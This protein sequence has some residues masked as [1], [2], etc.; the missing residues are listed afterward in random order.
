MIVQLRG[1]MAN[2]CFQAAFGISVAHA[3]QEPLYFHKFG[4]DNGQARAYSLGAFNI[5]VVF[6]DP[7]PENFTYREK[8]FAFDKDALLAPRGSYYCGLWQTERYFV[9]K[10][11]RQAFTPKNPLSQRSIEWK[12]KLL[13]KNGPPTCSIHVRRSDYLN[14]QHYHGLAGGMEYYNAAIQYIREKVNDRVR[15]FV[16]SDDHEWCRSNFP[17]DGF[18]IV[19]CNGFGNGRIG[20]R[21]EHEDIML[22]SFCDHAIIANSSFS[23]WG[24]W[25]GDQT[26]EDYGMKRIVIAPKDWFNP[27]GPAKSLDTSDVCPE[28]WTRI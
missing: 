5:E 19:D 24:A 18:S 25:L 26:A 27:T 9:K 17:K 8:T 16:F 28:R 7:A 4:L 10:L 11:V 22:M 12:M 3:R 21:T 23:W 6:K 14:V 1:G 20:P 13:G 15:F 2:Q